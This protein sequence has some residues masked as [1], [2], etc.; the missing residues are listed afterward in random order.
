MDD[1]DRRHAEQVL[2]GFDQSVDLVVLPE[3]RLDDGRGVYEKGLIDLLKD[4]R[5]AGL[6][7]SWGDEPEQRGFVE[8][9][10]A[11]EVIW[12]AVLGIPGGVISTLISA[13]LAQWFG[14]SPQSTGQV[15]VALV[16]EVIA[17]DGTVTRE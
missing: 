11:A 1:D 16:R 13:K 12:D 6:T 15:R 3:R 9:R 2:A 14:K 8:R 17:P 4:L 10:S 5:D 7:V